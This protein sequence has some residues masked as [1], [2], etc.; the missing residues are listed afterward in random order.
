M[1]LAA[2][3]GLRLRPITLTTPKPLVPVAG[4]AMLDRALDRL[5]EAGVANTVVNAHYLGDQIVRHLD[6]RPGIQLSEEAELLE[7]GGGVTYALPKLGTSAFFACNADIVWT[8]GDRPALARMAEVW[9]EAEMDALLLLHPLEQAVGFEGR[10]DFERAADGRL[11]WRQGDSAPYVF[12]GVQMLHPRLFKG[13]EAKPFSLRV[14]YDKAFQA[15]RLHGL[16]HDGGWYHV[17]TPEALAE[18]D[19]LLAGQ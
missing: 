18:I 16:V 12:T 13:L 1:L 4:R 10:G 11:S 5:A 3:Y 7:T 9:D 19:A 17:G 2:G 15:G 14:V 8:D 6:G